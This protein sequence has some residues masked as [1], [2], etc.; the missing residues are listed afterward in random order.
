M[1]DCL[2]QA[3]GMQVPV[4]GVMGPDTRSAVRTFQKQQGLRAS[5]ILGPDTEDALRSACGGDSTAAGG[6]GD[7]QQEMEIGPLT[8]TLTWQTN[9]NNPAN[10]LLFT[11][12]QTRDVAG[13]GVYIAVDTGKGNEI[14]KVGKTWS[15]KTNPFGDQRYRAMARSKPG[16]MFYVATYRGSR[17][18]AGAGGVLEMIEKTIARLL[19]RAG[20]RLPGDFK[21]FVGTPVQGNVKIRNI[22]PPPLHALLPAA[23]T[24]SGTDRK[25][26][27]IPQRTW[28]SPL[29]TTPGLLSLTPH[30]Y[31]NWEVATI[32]DSPFSEVE[33]LELTAELLSV[34]S[35]EE[36][37][38]FLGKLVK[39]AWKGLKKVG[40]FVGKVAKPLGGVL[41]G[42]A[43]A[44]LPFV[45]GA[46]GSF[47]PIPGVGT[48]LGSA[49]G[50]ALSKALELEFGEIDQ[51]DQEFEMARRFVRLAGTAARQAA[52]TLPEDAGEKD[53][54]EVVLNSARRHLP[55]LSSLQPNRGFAKGIGQQ[56]GG[57]WAR[58]G[59]RI[60]ALGT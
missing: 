33:E 56:P 15:F 17:G 13:G 30:T 21:P 12:E 55:T 28:K 39:G 41:K 57:T 23:Y 16:L 60:I 38:Q 24:A 32:Y 26:R 58:R 43:K 36:L 29:P 25:G 8:A 5:G 45:G 14:L 20:Q 9:P 2:N 3:L 37:E 10:P 6:A 34:A 1:Q 44:A 59:N 11:R 49:L 18:S 46:L 42:V 31:P 48:A 54:E 35:E 40:K 53:L 51:E 19:Y 47:I 7:A 22:L 27:A 50:G 4:T 52:L